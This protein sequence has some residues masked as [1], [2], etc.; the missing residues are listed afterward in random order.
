M[1]TAKIDEYRSKTEDCR[2]EASRMFSGADLAG[3]L[4]K[5]WQ[6]MADVEEMKWQESG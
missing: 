3:R 1:R 5:D 4:A 6:A 2:L